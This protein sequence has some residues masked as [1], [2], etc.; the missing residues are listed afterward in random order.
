MID[1]LPLFMQTHQSRLPSVL[2]TW[3]SAYDKAMEN[4]LVGESLEESYDLCREW[5]K[6]KEITHKAWSIIVA[7]LSFR[8][9]WTIK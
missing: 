9:A 1:Q 4:T 2:E 7:N 6:W 8:A 5:A 3:Q